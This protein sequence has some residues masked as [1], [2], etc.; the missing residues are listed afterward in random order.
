MSE[1]ELA[2]LGIPPMPALGQ[3]T[4]ARQPLGPPQGYYQEQA[5]IDPARAGFQPYVNGDEWVPSTFAPDDRDRLKAQM[6]AAG[7]YGTEGYTSGTW[8]PDDARAYQLVLESAN[9]MMVRDADVVINQ[10]AEEARR[11]P[12]AKGPRAPLVSRVSNPD[13]I[14]AVIRQAAYDL[15]GSRLSDEEE[16]R[17]I[18]LYQG[19]QG[20][21]DAAE[22]A[23]AGGP[24]GSSAT[25][26]QAAGVQNFAEAQ[27]EKLR[28]GDVAAHRHLDAFERILQSMGTMVDTPETYGGQGLPSTQG[29]EVL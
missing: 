21:A 3:T 18:S 6:N 7:L 5:I 11:S 10:M 2:K 15:T 20:A 28:P 17:L 16:A 19:Q 23:A 12:R 9:G 8:T 14:R 24:A 1:A 27:I 26:A 13:D 29:T 4:S 22:Y 25:V